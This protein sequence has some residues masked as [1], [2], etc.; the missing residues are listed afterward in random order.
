TH[1]GVQGWLPLSC[2]VLGVSQ[3]TLGCTGVA[4]SLKWWSR[5]FSVHTG[6]ASS[7]LW[8]SR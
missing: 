6:V 4:A 8:W 2:G 5:G 7:L 3:Y 1:W